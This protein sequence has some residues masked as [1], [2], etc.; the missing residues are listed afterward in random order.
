MRTRTRHAARAP[1]PRR[2]R[3]SRPASSSRSRAPTRDARHAA[4]R[5]PRHRAGTAD[6]QRLHRV[7]HALRDDGERRDLPERARLLR[8]C[9]VPLNWLTSCRRW[10][11]CCASGAPR[12]ID[13]AT[14]TVSTPRPKQ[15][16]RQLV[17]PSS[18][19]AASRPSRRPGRPRPSREPLTSGSRPTCARR[20]ERRAETHRDANA[21]QQ[22][23]D[24]HR[25]EAV[26]GEHSRAGGAA[27][28][29]MPAVTRARAGGRASRRPGSARPRSREIET[30]EQ[31]EIGGRQP[32]ACVTNGAK[33]RLTPRNTYDTKYPTENSASTLTCT[34]TTFPCYMKTFEAAPPRRA[35]QKRRHLG[36]GVFAFRRMIPQPREPGRPHDARDCVTS[37]CP[38]ARRPW[39]VPP[40]RGRLR[41]FGRRLRR[42][43][44]RA[45]RLAAHR[46]ARALDVRPAG[47]RRDPLRTGF[48]RHRTAD[49]H[50]Q[51]E[52]LARHHEIAVR[53]V[54]RLELADRHAV[55]AGERRHRLLA[56]HADQHLARVGYVGFHRERAVF[57]DV[58]ADVL[59]VVIAARHD[60]RRP[61]LQAHAGRNL[62][63]RHQ[64]IGVH[65]DLRRS[66]PAVPAR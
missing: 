27:N 62:V 8:I 54:P 48:R 22:P 44:L 14:I 15:M 29:N 3:R 18:Q 26:R 37:S 40:S 5:T 25:A 34:D 39:P 7:E 32:E 4:H 52:R 65:A 11:T 57:G 9:H 10:R 38:C 55:A 61:R 42:A 66:R 64:R 36:D 56:A 13:A 24:H 30:G 20:L 60:D 47:R 46:Q 59:V 12:P 35:Q 1:A 53:T 16:A 28:S 49:R 41:R 19:S 50:V 6:P 58:G 31:A 17:Q 2:Q 21:D 33:P 63:D 51:H 23:A 45:V 43:A